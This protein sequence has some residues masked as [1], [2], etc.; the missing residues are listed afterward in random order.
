MDKGDS[1]AV[2]APGASR[3]NISEI[4]PSEL[5]LVFGHVETKTD[6]VDIRARIRTFS[7]VET[8][9]DWE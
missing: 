2:A 5:T 3:L 6:P 1:G 7:D 9:E 8:T 4:G